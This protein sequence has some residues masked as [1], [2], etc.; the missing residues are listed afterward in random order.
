MSSFDDLAPVADASAFIFIGSLIRVDAAT[1]AVVSVEEAI[2]V[3]WGCAT[4]PGAR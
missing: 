1:T 2:K 3:L 4:S